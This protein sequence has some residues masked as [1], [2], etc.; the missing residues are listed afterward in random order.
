MKETECSYYPTLNIKKITKKKEKSL[1]WLAN[2][3]LE[4]Q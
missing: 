2:A 1:D 3:S 4:V